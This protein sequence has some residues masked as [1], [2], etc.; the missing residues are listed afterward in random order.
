MYLLWSFPGV[1]VAKDLPANAGNRRTGSNALQAG[2]N[3]FNIYFYL[4]IWL[5]WVLVVACG[6]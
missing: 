6:A 5:W 3:Y 1:S 2:I 4:F